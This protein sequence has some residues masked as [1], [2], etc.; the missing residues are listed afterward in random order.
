[1]AV[2]D[3]LSFCLNTMGQGGRATGDG[4]DAYGFAWCAFG[5]SPDSEQVESELPLTVTLSQH[6]KDSSGPGCYRGG[7][8]AVQQWMIHKVPSILSLCI[9]NGS[10]V[11]LAQPLFGGYAS[12]PVPGISIRKA[13]LLE[14]MQK[15]D[16]ELT[17]DHRAIFEKGD[18]GGEWKSELVARRPDVYQEGDLLFGFSGGGPG[19]GDPLDREPEAVMEDLKKNVISDVTAQNIYKV[20]YDLERRKVDTAGTDRLRQMERQARLARGKPY[21]EFQKEWSKKSPP[22]EILQWYGSWPD[23]KPT[24]PIIRH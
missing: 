19:Y 12:A 1:M 7:S 4:M 17:L 15:G 10:K 24:A 2:S 16:P 21:E 13:D 11:P 20:A 5:R 6:W 3:I 23:A 18:I 22:P 9:G 14:R 8:G